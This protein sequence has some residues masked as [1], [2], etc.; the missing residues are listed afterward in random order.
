VVGVDRHNTRVYRVLAMFYLTR[1]SNKALEKVKTD[2]QRDVIQFTKWHEKH[3]FAHQ[4]RHMR[5]VIRTIGIARARVKIGLANLAY[6]M[7][8]YLW[9]SSQNAIT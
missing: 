6:N 3:V 2:L 4:K 8:R 5:L 7:R 1:R 9:L